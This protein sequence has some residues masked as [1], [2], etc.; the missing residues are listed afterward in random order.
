VPMPS[1]L[2]VLAPA[3]FATVPD[4]PGLPRRGRRCPR[5]GDQ[6]RHRR[7]HGRASPPG[8]P[9]ARPGQLDKPASSKALLMPS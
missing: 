8:A 1:A 9:I 6:L 7:S 5:L 4:P 2:M 3:P